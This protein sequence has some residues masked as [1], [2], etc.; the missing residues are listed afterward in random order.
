M[1]QGESVFPIGSRL[2]DSVHGAFKG[3]VATQKD[4]DKEFLVVNDTPIRVYHEKDPASIGWGESGADYVCE[5]TGV[6]TV[7]EKAS[8]HHKGGAKKVVISAP[9]ADAPMFVMGVNHDKYW[10]C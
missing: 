6:F 10:Y 1:V 7:V 9:S 2:Y 5:S 3:T 8:S 4:G